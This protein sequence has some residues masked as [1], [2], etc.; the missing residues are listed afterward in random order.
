MRSQLWWCNLCLVWV[1]LL[2]V[3][4]VACGSPDDR[5]R[6]VEATGTISQALCTEERLAVASATAS[7]I[8]GSSWPAA[9]AVDGS[10][11]T[12]WSSAFSD[13]QWITLDLG[14]KRHLS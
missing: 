4:L 11:S 6:G 5:E 12:R 13:P 8:Q 3:T 14:A 1:L 9:K 7:S 2:A 10:M